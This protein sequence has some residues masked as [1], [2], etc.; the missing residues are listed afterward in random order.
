GGSIDGQPV[1]TWGETACFSLH[2][3]KNLN[4][5]SDGGVIVT[6]SDE[7]AEKLRLL[8]NHGLI[9]RDEVAIFG[10]NSRL[11]T[12]QAVVG[13][14][15]IG[16]TKWI[17]EQRIATA[18][19]Y[20]EAFADIEGVRIPIRRPGV[21]HVYHLYVIRSDRRDELLSYLEENGVEAKIHYPIPVH[22]QKGAEHLGY[23]EGDFPKCEE[24]CKNIITL[25][26]HQ[27]LT[28]D[29][30]AYTIEKVREFYA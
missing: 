11:D 25:P 24:D 2:P 15:L 8:R 12:L 20:D 10:G 23:S 7:M 4:V 5:W 26:A 28:D 30:I 13:N 1:G 29:E 16:Q 14:R 9:N 22:L 19:R 3:L 17:T 21:K 27:H 18:R 6:R